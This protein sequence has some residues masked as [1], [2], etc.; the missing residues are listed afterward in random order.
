MSASRIYLARA[1]DFL[2]S[3][4]EESLKLIR[5]LGEGEEQGFKP[6]RI[7]S[8][9]WHRRYWKLMNDL[10]QHI[11]EINIS[12][13]SEPVMM[14]VASAYDLHTAI[15]LITGHCITQHIKGT[16]YVLRIPK[17]T[18]FDSMTADEWSEF[19]PR[20]LD[21]VHE[22]ALPQIEIPEVEAELARMAS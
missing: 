16:G 18:D 4:D 15:K 9:P 14:P 19:Y 22:R 20:A 1:G 6:L 8:L 17:P 2:A 7:R 12:L 10:S 11:S 3:T 13:G 5:R 21:A